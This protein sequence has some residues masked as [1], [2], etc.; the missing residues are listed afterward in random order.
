L[1]R[2]ITILVLTCITASGHTGIN[3]QKVVTTSKELPKVVVR[4]VK[5][6]IWFVPLHIMKM[7]TK[8]NICEMGGRWHSEGSV[9]SG[10]LGIRNI[11]WVSFGGLKFAPNAG[12]ATPMQQVYIARKIEKSNYVPDQ[13]GCGQGW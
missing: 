1:R 2:L 6:P 9:Y 3:T 7:W 11:N 13:Y 4:V 12:R 5:K 8:V 10:G